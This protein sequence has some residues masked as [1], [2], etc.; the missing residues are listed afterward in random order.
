LRPVIDSIAQVAPGPVRDI[1]NTSVTGLESSS[2]KAGVVAVIG[3][4]VALW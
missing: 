1:I 3:L 2:S 4:V